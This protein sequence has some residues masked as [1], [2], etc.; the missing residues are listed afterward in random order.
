MEPAGARAGGWAGWKGAV[1]VGHQCHTF[2]CGLV[3]LRSLVVHPQMP[4]FY[5]RPAPNV[6]VSVS[7]K[8]WS[9]RRSIWQREQEVHEAVPRSLGRWKSENSV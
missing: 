5:P 6:L 2:L 9:L 7:L 8:T 1:A 4:E 3:L